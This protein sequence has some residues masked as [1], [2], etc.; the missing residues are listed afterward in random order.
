MH[1]VEKSSEGSSLQ[2]NAILILT[3][4]DFTFSKVS[5]V[6]YK[7]LV[8]SIYPA[9]RYKSLRPYISQLAPS[10]SISL[11]VTLNALSDLL[12]IYSI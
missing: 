1:P 8:F 9:G 11:V 7:V 5:S 3:S 2:L 4:L 10:I 6:L 12:F